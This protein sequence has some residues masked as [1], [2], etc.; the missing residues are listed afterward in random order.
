M[1]T[2]ELTMYSMN[3]SKFSKKERTFFLKQAAI[4]MGLKSLDIGITA[5]TSMFMSRNSYFYLFEKPS[6]VTLSDFLMTM[7]KPLDLRIIK[8]IA[9]DLLSSVQMLHSKGVVHLDITPMN[10]LVVNGEGLLKKHT[11][12][13]W[14]EA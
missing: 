2:K 3:K 7:D 11:D 6:E 8:R 14:K 5:L 4:F 1:E 9:F 13:R 10:I 12:K